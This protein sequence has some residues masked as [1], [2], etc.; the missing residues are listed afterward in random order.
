MTL[1]CP[2]R[3]TRLE[4]WPCHT[5]CQEGHVH[6][7]CL[8]A[9][10]AAEAAQLRPGSGEASESDLDA[11]PDAAHA[12]GQVTPRL[13][14]YPQSKHLAHARKGGLGQV[15]GRSR[16]QLTPLE[17]GSNVGGPCLPDHPAWRPFNS[18]EAGGCS[19]CWRVIPHPPAQRP[20]T[21]LVPRHLRGCTKHPE[22]LL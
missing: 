17:N 4:R 8:S 1:L 7:A 10:E 6:R 13:Q 21:Q 16:T 14:L 15:P 12:L 5:G 19:G 9:P 22:A 2:N 18:G 20:E 11:N 3:S